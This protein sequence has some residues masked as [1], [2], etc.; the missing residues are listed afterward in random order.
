MIAKKEEKLKAVELRKGGLS[1]SEILN[2]VPVAKST[3]SVWLKDVGL[4]KK[5][6]QHLTEK[7]K[8]AQIKAKEA[9][10][11]KRIKITEEIKSIARKE[12]SGI[13]EREMW[14]IGVA[15]YW[16]EGSK[17]KSINV[18][19]RTIFSNSDPLMIKL[20]LEWLKK[21]CKVSSQDIIFSVYLHESV[22]NRRQEI[23]K[24]WS[25]I[26]GYPLS[27]FKQVVWKKNKINTK[28]K[29]IGVNYYGLLRITIS[30]S[31]NLNRKISGWIEGICQ[32]WG[33]V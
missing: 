15:L 17:Q 18:S 12:I 23:L 11:A 26:T 21:F 9:C 8:L 22:Y 30:R 25:N 7:R 16:A 33:V 10:R 24:Y 31:T 2:L 13:S 6:K 28:R 20:F 19:T 29:N 32:N 27:Q 4:A 14:L 1:Y 3:L 5:Q